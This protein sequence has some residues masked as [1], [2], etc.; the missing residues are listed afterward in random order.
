[1]ALYRVEYVDVEEAY[2]PAVTDDK[3][4]LKNERETEVTVMD[5]CLFHVY[6]AS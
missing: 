1:M 6:N 4:S 3:K 2:V 5:P